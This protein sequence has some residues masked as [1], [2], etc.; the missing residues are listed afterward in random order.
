MKTQEFVT[1]LTG[2]VGATPLVEL[3]RFGEGGSFRAFGKLEGANPGG[4]MKDRVALR[5][6]RDAISSGHIVPGRTVLIESSSG[7]LGIGLAQMCAYFG[8]RFI[9]VVD[10]RSNPQNIAIMRALGAEV[11]IVTERDPATGEY[12][13][14]RIARVRELA[15][16]IPHGFWTDQYSNPLNARAHHDTMRE[17]T[18]AAPGPVD[19]LFC[20]TSSC[21]TLRGCAEY[22]RAHGLPTRI[23]AVDAVGSVIFG[24]PAGPRLIPGHGAAIRPKLYGDSLAD[25]VV[26]VDDAECVVGC[27]RLARLEAILAGGSSGAAVAALDHF[28]GRIPPG[29]ICV[30]I[31]PDRGERYLDTIYS[32]VWVNTHF[33]D[34]SYLWKNGDPES[35]PC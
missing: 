26:H 23:V 16:T 8:I 22:V 31:L 12:L 11:E 20:P 24:Q 19:L 34:I 15:A 5:M 28:R 35:T 1:G 6:V 17:I 27:R 30:L 2:A 4:S 33:G 13:P 25:H 7:N 3:T 32:D 14:V 18:E 21:G 29:A 10:A 9:C